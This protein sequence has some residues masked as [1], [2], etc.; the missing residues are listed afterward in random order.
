M[1]IVVL[2]S[3]YSAGGVTTHD[4]E[5]GPRFNHK[6]GCSRKNAFTATKFNRD[7]FPE[8]QMGR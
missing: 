5:I 3:Y 4:R 1:Y 6:T 7:Y 2:L 8:K